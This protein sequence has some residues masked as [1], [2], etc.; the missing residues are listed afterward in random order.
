MKKLIII[1]AAEPG[2]EILDI[3]SSG[4][5]G[6]NVQFHRFYDDFLQGD[7]IIN[8]LS[9]EL[10]C[11]SFISAIGNV[12]VRKKLYLQFIAHNLKPV[13]IVSDHA[14]ISPWATLAGGVVVYPQCSISTNA[15]IGEDVLVNYNAS[16]SHGVRIGAHGNICPGVRIAGNVVLGERVY[17][18]IGSVIKERVSICDNVFIGANS[19]VLKDI[20]EPGIYIGSP[21]RLLRHHPA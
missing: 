18:G 2:Q 5:Q 21:C 13:N 19:T 9:P 20:T 17:I 6:E 16:I 3:L 4:C 11:M 1:G 8:T 12:Q 10:D 7:D 15:H 14:W